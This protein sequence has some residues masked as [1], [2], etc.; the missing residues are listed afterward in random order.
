MDRYG[1]SVRRPF[2][3]RVFARSSSVLLVWCQFHRSHHLSRSD[4][5]RVFGVSPMAIV[6]IIGGGQLGMMLTEAAA[7]MPQVSKVVVLDPT[8][9]CPAAQAGA[10]QITA[11][12]DDEA[13]LQELARRADVITY[14]I[15]SGDSTVLE[16]LQDNARI[17]PP[18]S[19]LAVIQD[20]L[21]QKRMLLESGIPVAPFADAPSPDKAV[22]A[23]Q[24]LKYPLVAKSRRGGY[25]GR[26]NFVVS[27]E[28]QM[29]AAFEALRG[30]LMLERKVNF[31]MEVSVVA[32]RGADGSRAAYPAVENIHEGGILRTTFAPARTTDSIS[33]KAAE[34][35]SRVMDS[36]E[37]AGVFGI[38]MFVDGEQVLVNEIAPRVHNSG[39]HTLQSC[40]TS[41]FEQHLRAVL[42]M[43][44]GSTKIEHPTIM[45]NI[46]GEHEGPYEVSEPTGAHT[47]IYRK[48]ES[49]LGRKMGHANIVAA[50]SGH[51]SEL[52]G[53]LERIRAH[54]FLLPL[55]KD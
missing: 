36:L 50:A 8:P 4:K 37:G 1:Q 2:R 44:L 13:G 28:S 39:H 43:P 31:S 9:R 33:H 16:R 14:E 15:E 51:L 21:L 30:P 27:D 25:D 7:G 34:L 18:P 12:F 40:Q 32:V 26:G 48:A 47:K 54:R 35:A 20:K 46:L 22:E 29:S 3:S 52:E 45:H 23:A 19:T 24:D 55:T 41:Q 10:D 49:R 6:G 38:E 5:L 11:G 42:G 17:C 53:E